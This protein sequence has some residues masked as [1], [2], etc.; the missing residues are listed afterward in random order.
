MSFAFGR[1][2]GLGSLSACGG[3]GADVSFGF[4]TFGLGLFN[5]GQLSF[6]NDFGKK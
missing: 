2:D 1:L 3:G 4:S 5:I 6:S